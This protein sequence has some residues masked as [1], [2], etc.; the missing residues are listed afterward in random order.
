MLGRWYDPSDRQTVCGVELAEN[1]PTPHGAR[2]KLGDALSWIATNLVLF[3][4]VWVVFM[5]VT[6]FLEWFLFGS[7]EDSERTFNDQAGDVIYGLLLVGSAL[8]LG[9]V[10]YLTLLLALGRRRLQWQRRVIALVL[11]PIVGIIIWFWGP[12]TVGTLIYGLAF[13]LLCGV[14]VRFPDGDTPGS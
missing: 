3:A 5:L 1:E 10:L 13:P 6:G 12:F 4:C 8:L 9:A 14:I 2:A 7:H 11:S